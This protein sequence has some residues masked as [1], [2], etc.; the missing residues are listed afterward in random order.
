MK[1]MVDG[2][3]VPIE[4]ASGVVTTTVVR[5]SSKPENQP[6]IEFEATCSKK[7]VVAGAISDKTVPPPLLEGQALIGS[8][9]GRCSSNEPIQIHIKRNGDFS[10]N[11]T[12][13][14]VSASSF[15]QSGDV[16]FV[17]QGLLA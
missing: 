9:M 11:M 14:Q 6:I 2:H 13:A 15:P 17:S 7:T 3:A 8:M 1:I 12:C 4:I 10:E 16:R 5:Q